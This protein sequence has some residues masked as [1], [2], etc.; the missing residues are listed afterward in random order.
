MVE[1]KTGLILFTNNNFNIKRPL[2]LVS[3]VINLFQ[4]GKLI[5]KDKLP[6]HTAQTIVLNGLLCVIDS[7]TRGI[8]PIEFERWKHN[9]AYIYIFD[10]MILTTREKT[11]EYE[12]NLLVNS[13]VNYD[14][15]AI[16]P[17]LKY[18]LLGKYHGESNPEKADDNFICSELTAWAYNYPNWWNRSPL[19]LFKN[20]FIDAPFGFDVAKGKPEEITFNK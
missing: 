7:D 9:R 1:A 5:N 10:P 14:F 15:K 3:G 4:T 6:T 8:I 17:Q 18:Q 20:R 12:K 16:M 19:N 2:S 13:G 11:A